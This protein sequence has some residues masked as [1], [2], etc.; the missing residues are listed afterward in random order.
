MRWRSSLT[1]AVAALAVGAGF[2][3]AFRPEP[4]PVD[5]ATIARGTLEVTVDEEGK[6][7][8]REI[9]TVSAPVSGRVLR[10]PREVGDPV[11]E[12]LTLVGVILPEL[13]TIQDER[14]R[15]ELRANA[16]AAAAAL[17]LAAAERGRA[18]A[19][20]V[21]WQDQ[22]AR[23]AQLRARGALSAQALA[24]TRLE[25]AIR[26]AAVATAD[27]RIEVRRQEL[28]RAEALLL[29]PGETL[30]LDDDACCVRVTTPAD[31]VVLELL[32][33]SE[34]VVAA[35]T[36]LLTIGDP[37]DLEIVVELLSTDAVRI[38]PGA[39]AR[40]ERWGGDETLP[41][42]VRRIEPTGFTKVSALGIEEQRVRVLLD[43]A[44]PAD[45]WTHLGHAF[46]VFAHIVVQR[47]D[48]VPLLPMGALFRTGDRWTV[49]TVEDGRARLRTLEIGAR[50]GRLAEV[51][52]GLDP[53]D[54]VV[55]HPSARVGDGIRVVAR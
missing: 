9:F 8:I 29:Q 36:P 52:A 41:A 22:L 51:T 30:D 20:R 37:A 34:Q 53:G 10:N 25:L 7:R 5:L 55:L 47:R 27:A 1:V 49:Y 19:E 48:D 39:E 38:R 16:R 6:T 24:Q 43:F 4:V 50:T 28:A 2:Y 23:D 12:G 11:V 35:G 33:E 14:T 26:E 46:R 44:V 32:V 13:P 31:G 54:R 15:G 40:I 3:L 18:E 17:D 45:A 21:Y 42:V